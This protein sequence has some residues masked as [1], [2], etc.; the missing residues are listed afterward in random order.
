MV[1]ISS[2]SLFLYQPADISL[3][4]GCRGAYRTQGAPQFVPLCFE[5]TK[6]ISVGIIARHVKCRY[7]VSA[8]LFL[9]LHSV[10]DT[11]LPSC[12]QCVEGH[13]ECVRGPNI[14]FRNLHVQGKDSSSPF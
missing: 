6:S 5:G 11:R 14:R 4:E 12:F 9:Y 3:S 8:F 1:T 7:H 10:G 13:I 2:L